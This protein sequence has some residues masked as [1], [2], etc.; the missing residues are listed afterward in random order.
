MEFLHRWSCS[1]GPFFPVLDYSWLCV[2]PFMLF[3]GFYDVVWGG[4]GINVGLLSS[5][6]FQ[7]V[8]CEPASRAHVG[9]VA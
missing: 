5:L 4:W 7:F 3:C 6:F 2:L 1:V 8:S 9:F